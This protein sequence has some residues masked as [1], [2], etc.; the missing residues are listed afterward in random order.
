[1]RQKSPVFNL[2]RWKWQYANHY[3]TESAMQFCIKGA[4][5]PGV[6]AFIFVLLMLQSCLV[7]IN[8]NNLNKSLFQYFTLT[9]LY[10]AMT[11]LLYIYLSSAKQ[12]EYMRSKYSIYMLSSGRI[13]MCGVYPKNVAYI[14]QAMHDAIKLYPSNASHDQ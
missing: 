6:Q 7:L 14:A 2:W 9:S 1:M 8:I 12:V 3:F 10:T 5:H 11:I 13:S 4:K